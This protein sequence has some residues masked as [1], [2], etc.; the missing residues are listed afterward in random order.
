MREPYPLQQHQLELHLVAA[1]PYPIRQ[2][3]EGFLTSYFY[4]LNCGI[5]Y[6]PGV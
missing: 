3:L 1:G 5:W 4:D 6:L 2:F